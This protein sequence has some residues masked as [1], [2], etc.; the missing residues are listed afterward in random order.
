ML[1]AHLDISNVLFIDYFII[2][3]H[4][5]YACTGVMVLRLYLFTY[6][7]EV[8]MLDVL[9]IFYYLS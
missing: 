5:T 6:L 3:F 1:R 7:F 8:Q 2:V 4:R 9:I